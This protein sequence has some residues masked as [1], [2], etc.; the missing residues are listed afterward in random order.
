LSN[1]KMQEEGPP[2]SLA[3]AGLTRRRSQPHLR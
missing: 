2:T 1:S 3:Q